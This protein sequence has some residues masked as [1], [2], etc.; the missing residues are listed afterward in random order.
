M[1]RQLSQS[2]KSSCA[3]NTCRGCYGEIAEIV[4]ASRGLYK[5]QTK[6][7]GDPHQLNLIWRVMGEMVEDLLIRKKSCIVPDFFH[8]SIKVQKI[9]FWT[10]ERLFYKPQ[11]VLLPDFTSKFHLKN[12]LVMP[13]AHYHQTV[14]CSISYATIGGMMGTD[15]YT[16]EAAIKDSVREIGKYLIRNPQATLTIDIGPAFLEFRGRE[17]R[18]KWCPEFLQRL[19]SAVGAEAVVSPYDPPSLT[20]GG[21]T[22]PCRLEAGC[23]TTGTLHEE[24]FE[25]ID[26]ESRMTVAEMND[27]MGGSGYRRTHW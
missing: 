19:Q 23:L 10:G 18:I 12:V 22:A 13:D 21:P 5:V 25:T 2:G 7:T 16:V 26:A 1:Q 4:S 6:G 9:R 15:R 24:V 3:P 20:K 11:F 17:Y 8:V 27:G 14:P